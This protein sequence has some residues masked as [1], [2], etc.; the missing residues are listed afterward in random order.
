MFKLNKIMIY[1]FREVLLLIYYW[2]TLFKDLEKFEAV[3]DNKYDCD[4][5]KE[6]KKRRLRSYFNI[7]QWLSWSRSLDHTHNYLHH[8]IWYSHS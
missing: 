6:N 7:F 8:Y 2:V 4:S 3:K 5:S 1:I